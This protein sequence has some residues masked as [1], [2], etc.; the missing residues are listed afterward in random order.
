M[1]LPISKS[2][3]PIIDQILRNSKITSAGIR[4]IRRLLQRT[5]VE[6]ID[7]NRTLRL[8]DSGKFFILD[9][10]ATTTITLPALSARTTGITYTFVVKTTN[11]SGDGYRIITGDTDDGSAGDQY[12]GYCII[13]TDNAAAEVTAGSTEAGDYTHSQHDHQS[14]TGTGG[15]G[16]GHTHSIADENTRYIQ[17][18]G[19]SW[20]VQ[21]F[22]AV[23]AHANG[24][25]V[26]PDGV[27]DNVIQLDDVA[28]PHSGCEPGTTVKL[29]ALDN[30]YWYA[31]IILFTD[32]VGCDGTG[33]FGDVG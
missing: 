23:T 1:P 28:A 20:P 33:V 10:L 6:T 7:G 15:G 9:N 29:T 12:L 8:E 16:A 13:G 27:N 2:E 5:I 17:H 30:R 26:R 4:I 31:E 24:R 3:K 21:T 11:T 19:W 25:I 14:N 18:S 32:K 22:T